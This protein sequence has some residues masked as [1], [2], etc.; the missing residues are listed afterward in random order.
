VKKIGR[1]EIA[2]GSAHLQ[3]LLADGD[4]LV[5][6]Y[7]PNVESTGERSLVFIG[8]KFC[9]AVRKMPFQSLAVAGEAGETLADASARD[10]EYGTA[11]LTA[12]GEETLY[13]RVD[14]VHD[15]AGEPLLLE[16]E[17]IEPSL[18]LSMNPPAADLFVEELLARASQACAS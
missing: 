17:L 15:D 7:I 13:A 12:L 8:G 6:P 1:N 16:L 5:Q 14:I 18:F 10:I 11:V 2:A 9:H 3:S 4:A